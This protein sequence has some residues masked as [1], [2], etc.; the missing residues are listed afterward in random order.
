MRRIS[1]TLEP[2]HP[3]APSHNHFRISPASSGLR[4]VPV[5]IPITTT[6]TTTSTT[7][8]TG[9][10]ADADEALRSA[11]A[12]VAVAEVAVAAARTPEEATAALEGH[13]SEEEEAEG[14]PEE[15]ESND[16]LTV[17]QRGELTDAAMVTTSHRTAGRAYLRVL[18][19]HL[20]ETVDDQD[21]EAE[22]RSILV[23]QMAEMMITA[24]EQ[25]P[26]LALWIVEMLLTAVFE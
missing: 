13:Q 21:R 1:P 25:H 26:Y 2:R 11:E 17:E 15:E 3:L 22:D 6:M 4:L 18:R 10:Q 16:A 7:T 9:V 12:A 24:G 20:R 23:T 5:A 14:S 8:P 19:R